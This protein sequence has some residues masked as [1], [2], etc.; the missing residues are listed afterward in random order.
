MV[1]RFKARTRFEIQFADADHYVRITSRKAPPLT[2]REAIDSI[3]EFLRV[4]KLGKK[5]HDR[6]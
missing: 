3:E 6:R 2:W 4:V 1:K 5:K